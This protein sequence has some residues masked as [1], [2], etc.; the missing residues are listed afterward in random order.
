MSAKCPE[1][2]VEEWKLDAQVQILNIKMSSVFQEL[3]L[4]VLLKS[5]QTMTL[6]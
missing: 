5:N 4:N 6:H 2:G 1:A 3:F